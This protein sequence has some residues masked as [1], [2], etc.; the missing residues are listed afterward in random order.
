[1]NEAVESIPFEKYLLKNRL[2][3][4][5]DKLFLICDECGNE[6]GAYQSNRGRTKSFCDDCLKKHRREKDKNYFR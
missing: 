3:L 1:M 4:K 5:E 6:I 2:I